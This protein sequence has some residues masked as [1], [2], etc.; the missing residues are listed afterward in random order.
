MTVNEGLNLGVQLFAG[1]GIFYIDGIFKRLDMP[2]IDKFE[3]LL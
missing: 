3:K 1:D 2:V